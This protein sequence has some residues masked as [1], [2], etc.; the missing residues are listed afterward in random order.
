MKKLIQFPILGALAATLLFSTTDTRAAQV[1][2][3]GS[4][5]YTFNSSVRFYGMGAPQYGR[6]RNLGADY[7]RNTT[8]SM[9]WITNRSQNNSGPLSFEYWGMPFYGSDTGI[10]L[11]TRSAD[12]LRAGRYYKNRSWRGWAVFLDEY[13]FPEFSIWESTRNGWRFRDALSF[14]RDNLL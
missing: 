13:R 2:L 11:M 9:E 8:I 12:P 6:Y 7:Y 4:G 1:T 5:Y 3:D 14:R 10:V